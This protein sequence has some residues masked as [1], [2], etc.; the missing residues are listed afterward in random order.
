MRIRGKEGI[1]VG[2]D[3]YPTIHQLGRS[4]AERF[5][6]TPPTIFIHESESLVPFTFTAEGEKPMIVLPGRVVAGFE[7]EELLFVIG[8]ECGHIHNGHGFFHTAVEMLSNPLAKEILTRG[9]EASLARELAGL[10]SRL[11]LVAKVVRGSLKL[12]FS[13]WSRCARITCDRAGLICCGDPDVARQALIKTVLGTGDY[14]E[15]LNLE[16]YLRQLA[17]HRRES[18]DLA[19]LFDTDA[20]VLDRIRAV[21]LFAGCRLYHQWRG[22]A[23]PVDHL[24]GMIETDGLVRAPLR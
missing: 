13:R 14:L 16:T 21:E 20:F 7:P 8:H 23:L 11:G 24:P 22:A 10:V 9:A 15:Q 3:Q 2:P 6:I 1:E 4:C 19:S 17:T 12:F 5:G 18:E